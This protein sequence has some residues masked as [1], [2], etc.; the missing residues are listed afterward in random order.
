MIV[1]PC[2]N[3]TRGPLRVFKFGGTSV[4]DANCIQKVV[5]I[6]KT[7]RHESQLLVVVSAMA[8]VTNQL[9]EAASYAKAG[10][11]SA[12]VTILDALRTRHYAVLTELLQCTDT[13]NRIAGKMEELFDEA[14]RLC[15]G[16]SLLRELTLRVQDAITGLG[17]RLSAPLV[18]AALSEQG[19]PSQSVEATEL[20]ITDGCHGAAEPKLDL[21]RKCCEARLT[22]LFVHSIVPVITGFIGSTPE[23]VQTTLGRGGS[24]YSAAILGMAVDASEVVIWTDVDGILTADPHLLPEAELIGEISYRGAAELAYFGAKVLHPKTLSP[25]SRRGIPVWIRNTFGPENPGTKITPDWQ[26]ANPGVTALTLISDAALITISGPEMMDAPDALGRATAIA[27]DIR[28]DVFLVSQSSS[29]SEICLVM[30]SASAAQMMECLRRDFSAELRDQR[31]QRISLDRGVAVVTVVGEKLPEVPGIVNRTFRA[32]GCAAVDTLAMS[33]GASN[34]SMAVSEKDARVALAAIHR[35][36]ALEAS[37]S[38]QPKQEAFVLKSGGGLYE[39][40]HCV[41]E[42]D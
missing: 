3:P 42:A 25:L 23:G 15:K 21:T 19:I 29:Q 10:N 17:E 9:I 20:I 27:R 16:T 11:S 12:A 6:I 2:A 30:R 33:Y 4:A 36:F 41:V 22:T 35:E 39:G 32:L 1:G 24:D 5:Q 14:S 37:G 28:A 7:A 34:I 8:G 18:A 31:F 13:R 26:R 40:Q 38:K